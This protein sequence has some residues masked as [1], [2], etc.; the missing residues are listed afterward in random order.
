MRPGRYIQ[1]T[2]R[3]WRV[4]FLVN[5]HLYWEPLLRQLDKSSH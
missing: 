3:S 5:I 1:V 2:P 4:L